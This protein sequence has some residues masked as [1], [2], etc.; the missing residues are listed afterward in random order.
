MI[1]LWWYTGG[2]V[3]HKKVSWFEAVRYIAGPDF[4]T[5]SHS[6]NEMPYCK[7]SKM[8]GTSKIPYIS[9]ACKFYLWVIA[10]SHE[11]F[12][13]VASHTAVFTTPSYPPMTKKKNLSIP[14]S[15]PQT[16]HIHYFHTSVVDTGAGR[17]GPWW[18]CPLAKVAPPNS[19]PRN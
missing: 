9:D 3:L 6:S 11:M 7:V 13:D 16:I 18:S 19:M 1:S 10:W 2:T 8:Y 4:G 15:K 12:F 17:S 5:A 14:C